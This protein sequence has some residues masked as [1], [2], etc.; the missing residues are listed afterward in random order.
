MRNSF[1]HPLGGAFFFILVALLSSNFAGW[2]MEGIIF[3][4]FI[5]AGSVVVV[6]IIGGSVRRS[7]VA[8]LEG[9]HTRM[10]FLMAP[11]GYRRNRLAESP[12]EAARQSIVAPTPNRPLAKGD[13]VESGKPLTVLAPQWAKG[14]SPVMYMAPDVNIPINEFIGR[15]ITGLGIRG[16]GKTHLAAR[17]IE[18][19]ARF[20][21][22]ML[23]GDPDGDYDT[24]PL[25]LDRCV[26]AGHPDW[27]AKDNYQG[28]YWDVNLENAFQTG[29]YL[30]EIGYQVVL[31]MRSYPTKEE[32]AQVLVLIIRGLFSWA[33]AQPKNRRVPCLVF[34]DEAQKF[35]PENGVATTLSKATISSML[36]AFDDLNSIGRKRGLTP[37]L[38][39]QRIA[40]IRKSAIS[41]TEV[42]FFGKQEL[43]LD[44]ERYEEFIGRDE[45]GKQIVNRREMQTLDAGNFY[46][47]EDGEYY[48]VR[49]WMRD[50]EHKSITPTF[51]DAIDRYGD[52]EVSREAPT[53]TG[54]SL[55][56]WE[57][58]HAQ[59]TD[60]E[61]DDDPLNDA[62]SNQATQKEK[63]TASP[64]VEKW[65]KSDDI[66][67]DTLVNAWN[68]NM[69]TVDAI[70]SFFHMKRGEAY[71]A[72]KRV[73]AQ[74]E[75]A[76]EPVEQE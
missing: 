64:I 6:P 26:I 11:N 25:L 20:P 63:A 29:E 7:W 37:C 39:T 3:A 57:R 60:L 4:V 54:Y 50:S 75:P 49:F 44:L 35:L 51:K 40:Q 19:L 72:Y 65:T 56:D 67:I 12:E 48:K 15:A 24:L 2:G 21:I 55:K 16:S 46:V 9:Q 53:A 59:E 76:S 31:S 62:S 69:N 74:M 42:W 5:A 66:H 52:T 8:M 36:S 68:M 33:E 71:K 23:I 70:K 34:L 10:D 32:A 61:D 22:P 1:K 30:L 47:F 18:Q 58:D 27:S 14:G 17:I 45:N 13:T 73:Q 28:Y 43:P 38:F 41:G